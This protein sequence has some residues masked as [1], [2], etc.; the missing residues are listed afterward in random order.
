MQTTHQPHLGFQR[1]GL[2]LPVSI[3]ESERLRVLVFS[4]GN[5]AFPVPASLEENTHFNGT[6]SVHPPCSPELPKRHEET[7]SPR[8][9][10]NSATPEATTLKKAKPMNTGMIILPEETDYVR[11]DPPTSVA[12]SP[13]GTSSKSVPPPPDHHPLLA[14]FPIE[15]EFLFHPKEGIGSSFRIPFQCITVHR[16]RPLIYAVLLCYLQ[17]DDES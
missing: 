12:Y 15:P 16:W 14:P 4:L 7:Q 8:P 10:L 6:V 2:T 17:L 9:G 5:K 1:I 3:F 11:L 13:S